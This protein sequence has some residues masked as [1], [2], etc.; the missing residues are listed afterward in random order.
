MPIDL[1]NVLKSQ[2]EGYLRT[3]KTA[4]LKVGIELFFIW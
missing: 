3:T 2:D 1:V 4:N